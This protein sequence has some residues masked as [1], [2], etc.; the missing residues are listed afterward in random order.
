M[1]GVIYPEAVLNGRK[2]VDHRSGK[3]H[4]Q[5]PEWGISTQ[6]ASEMLGISKR[7]TRA[8]LNRH[9]S[10]CCLVSRSGRC[11]CLYWE[12]KV[13]ERVLARRM[14]MVCKEPEKLCSA[15]EACFI[16]LVARSTLSRYVKQGLLREY[17]V[18]HA[19]A[20]GVRILS[21]FLRSDVR[22]LAARRKAAR[23][24][25]EVQRREQLRQYW[26][27]RIGSAVSRCRNPN[28]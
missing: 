17:R 19:S 27:G 24:R 3:P 10:E 26:H 20:N 21:R 6:E 14:P 4:E 8:L 18:R 23:A 12:R 28:S 16:L 9:K 2:G 13:V 5:P 22:Q 11:A 25:A 1:P 15:D 7:A